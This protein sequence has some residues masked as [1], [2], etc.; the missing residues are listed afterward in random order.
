MYKKL[1]SLILIISLSF[2][3]TACEKKVKTGA[4]DIH[5]DRDMCKRCIMVVSD[6]N[7]T[8]QVINPKD[9]E[10]YVFDDIGCTILW[11]KDQDIKWK[12]DA[13]IWINDFNTA[14]WIDARTAFYDTMN[15][16]P[17]AYG[18]GAHK[19]KDSIQAGLEIIDFKEVS[20]RI[21]EIGR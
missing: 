6:R 17:M 3:F 19:K 8:V 1:T 18:F 4:H 21:L 2:L 15:V 20:K 5:W 16:T 11:F 7:Q 14:K 9:G 13:I 10:K 12:D